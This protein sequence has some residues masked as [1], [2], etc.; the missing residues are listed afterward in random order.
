MIVVSQ[1]FRKYFEKMD[2]QVQE[3]ITLKVEQ[4]DRQLRTWRHERLQ[5]RSEYKLRVGDWR[6]LYDLDL[7][8]N[9]LLLLTVRHRREVYR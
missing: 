2:L 3:R 9:R 1:T 8:Q 6:V 4:V 5:G 7:A